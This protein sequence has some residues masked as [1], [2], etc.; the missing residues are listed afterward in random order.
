MAQASRSARV[1]LGSMLTAES[2]LRCCRFALNSASSPSKVCSAT[3][4]AT[5]PCCVL[6]TFTALMLSGARTCS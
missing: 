2:A 5:V 3:T 1:L 6:K 4:P